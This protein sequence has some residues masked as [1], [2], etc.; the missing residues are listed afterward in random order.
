MDY[1]NEYAKRA[2]SVSAKNDIKK[3]RETLKQLLDATK[4]EFFD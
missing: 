3:R 4:K 1:L 2:K